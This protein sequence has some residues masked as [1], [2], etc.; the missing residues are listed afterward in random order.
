MLND[1][2]VAVPHDDG[3]FI[4]E[5]ISRVVELIRDYDYTLDVEW[6]PPSVRGE[7]DAFRIIQHKP[8]GTKYVVMGVRSEEDFDERI[9]AR[10]YEGDNKNGDVQQRMEANNQAIRDYKRKVLEEIQDEQNQM[11]ASVLRSPKSIYRIGNTEF[12]DIP[13]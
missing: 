7:N 8:D 10:L 6:I 13:R 5:R 12:R 11:A 2:S 1:F 4:S 9:L 3:S